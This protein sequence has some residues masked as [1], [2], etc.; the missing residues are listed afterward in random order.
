MTGFTGSIHGDILFT[1]NINAR[2]R[3]ITGTNSKTFVPESCQERPISLPLQNM[4]SNIFAYFYGDSKEWEAENVNIA[5]LYILILVWNKKIYTYLHTIYT[6]LL[7]RVT[8]SKLAS[9]TFL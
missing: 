8:F 6:Y 9:S 7:S 2:F 4:A 5:E 1:K 3:V